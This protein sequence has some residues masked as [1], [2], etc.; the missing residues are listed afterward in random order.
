MEQARAIQSRTSRLDTWIHRI[1]INAALQLLRKNKPQNFDSL[2]FDIVDDS[3]S[4][5]DN[6]LSEELSETCQTP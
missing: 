5:E 3:E 2:D 1:A 6:R 4:Q